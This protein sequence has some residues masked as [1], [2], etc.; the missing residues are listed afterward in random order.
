[1]YW[2]I[3]LLCACLA[4]I[5]GLARADHHHA[6]GSAQAT[7]PPLFDDLGTLHHAVTTSSPEAQKYFD[8]GLRL[9]YAFNHDEVNRA[10]KEAA[11]LDPNCAM[12]YWGVAFTL[13]PNYNL[14][15]DAER[16]RAAYEAIQQVLALA[17]QAS[18]AECA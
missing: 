16:D 2:R 18:E 15:V 8:Q 17:P 5:T 10:F 7:T 4:G 11:R 12:A 13:G 6:H 3:F 14:P 1:M 9:V